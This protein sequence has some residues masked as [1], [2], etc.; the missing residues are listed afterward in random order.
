MSDPAFT[1]VLNAGIDWLC[2][3]CGTVLVR[4][5]VHEHEFLDLL[6]KC[7]SCQ[8][9]GGSPARAPG[10]PLAGLPLLVPPGNYLLGSSVD[11][12][13][14][15]VMCIGQQALDGYLVETGKGQP[16]VP[17][18]MSADGLRDA[19]DYA[20]ALLGD[21]YDALVEADK[22]GRSS[23]TPP[24]RRHRMI[25]LI[26]CARRAATQLDQRQPGAGIALDANVLSELV[27]VVTLFR[28]WSKHPTWCKLVT[29]LGHETELQHSLMLLAVASYLVDAGNGVGVV[30][31][32]GTGRIADLWTEPSLL[33]R[34]DV[35]VKTPQEL[36]GPRE[37][38]LQMDDAVRIVERQVKKAASSKS[39]QL[40]PDGSGILALGAFHLGEGVLDVLKAAVENVLIRQTGR[41]QHLAGIVLAELSYRTETVV[42]E[43]GRIVITSFA[44][45]L[46]NRLVRHPGYRGDLDLHEGEPPWRQ[47]SPQPSAAPPGPRHAA[48]RTRP[49]PA[50]ADERRAKRKKQRAARRRNRRS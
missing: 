34:L 11:T 41:K 47:F 21:Q 4:G 27:T 19:A 13:D 24:T 16:T 15:A 40:K 43:R 2:P 14:K 38:P 39:G 42:D 23:P 9:V 28:R 46:E 45:S 7:Y 48:Q 3:S 26:Q 25:E 49:S 35:E 12:T 36:R 50:Q 33:E 31:E 22:R 20:V 37:S 18:E 1:G 32:E 17:V 5:A 6:F 10:R 8:T 29:T 30:G 44:P